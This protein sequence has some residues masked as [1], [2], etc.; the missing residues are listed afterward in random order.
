MLKNPEQLE[1]VQ[2]D[3]TGKRVQGGISSTDVVMSAYVAGNADVFPHILSL[4][5][6]LR[7]KIADVTHGG[8]VFW[9]NVDLSK[10]ELLATD[11]ATGV[12]CRALPYEEGSIDA[13]VLDPPYMEGLLR[14][15]KE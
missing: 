6:P 3:P 9:R 7:A 1:L 14:A 10:Y 11:I 8:G 13:L 4:H 5:V 15:K 2:T 12:D